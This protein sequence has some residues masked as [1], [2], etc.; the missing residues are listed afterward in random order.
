MTAFQLQFIQD[1]A[2][3]DSYPLNQVEIANDVLNGEST[4]QSLIESCEE[5]A[6]ALTEIAKE[7]RG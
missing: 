5:D 6:L 7:L 3:S 4:I 1:L 2:E